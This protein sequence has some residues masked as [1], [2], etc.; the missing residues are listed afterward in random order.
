M[1]P[2]HVVRRWVAFNAVGVMGAAVQLGVLAALVHW[3]GANSVI[4][5]ALAVEAAVVHNFAWH[6]RW[7]WRERRAAGARVVIRRLASFQLTNGAVSLVGNV[8]FTRA[9][10]GG[11]QIDPVIANAAAIV[12]CSLINF[13][14][15]SALVFRLKRHSTTVKST[16][17]GTNGD[18]EHG[19]GPALSALIS[20][21]RTNYP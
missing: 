19:G 12:A 15:S 10:S 1:G 16:S 5:T 4:A 3:C 9:L 2:V 8:W 11:F 6:Q 20:W 13:A 21:A 17:V 14:A 18:N 7:T